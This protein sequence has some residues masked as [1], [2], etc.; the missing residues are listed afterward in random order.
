M[1]KLIQSWKAKGDFKP[2]PPSPFKKKKKQNQ[3]LSP[4]GHPDCQGD[5]QG[6]LLVRTDDSSLTCQSSNLHLIDHPHDLQPTAKLIIRILNKLESTIPTNFI[7]LLRSV[8]GQFEILNVVT[9]FKLWFSWII[10]TWE[11]CPSS[12][13]W[14]YPLSNLFEDWHQ[15]LQNASCPHCLKLLF[16]YFKSL[17]WLF[18]T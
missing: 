16:Y 3:G 15:I 1:K 7:C 4:Q 2:Y 12:L 5:S 6:K 10:Q 8:G 13:K 17:I 9:Y 11:R 14:V 18:V